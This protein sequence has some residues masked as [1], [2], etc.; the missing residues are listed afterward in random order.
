MSLEDL[1]QKIGFYYDFLG[2]FPGPS[3]QVILQLQ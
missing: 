2:F 1:P 3:D